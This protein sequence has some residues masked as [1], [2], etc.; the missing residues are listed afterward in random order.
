MSVC[1]ALSAAAEEKADPKAEGGLLERIQDLN[2]TDEQE[3]KIADIRKEYRPKVQEAAK[4]LAGIVK[5][6]VEKV[7]AV[8]T[9]SR[10]RSSPTEGGAPGAAGRRPGPA[11]RAPGRTGSDRRRDGQ[12]RGDPEGVP[13]QDRK[14][15]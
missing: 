1:S 5:E 15:P 3:A 10:R 4:E 9:R 11:D 8:L 7:R 14:G 13:A 12:D 6:E 2:L